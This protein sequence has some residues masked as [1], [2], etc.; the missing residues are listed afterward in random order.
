MSRKKASVPKMVNSGW[1]HSSH[2]FLGSSSVGQDGD[3]LRVARAHELL[4]SSEF[5]YWPMDSW[6]RAGGW[7]GADGRLPPHPTSNPAGDLPEP[8]HPQL[9]RDA[10][11]SPLEGVLG[12]EVM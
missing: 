5:K 3:E 11:A 4:S 2:R 12:T 7:S 6:S 8:Q 9:S 10:K 1:Y